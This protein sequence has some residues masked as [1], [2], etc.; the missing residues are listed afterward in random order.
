MHVGSNGGTVHDKIS[1]ECGVFLLYYAFGCVG[2][3]VD[4]NLELFLSSVH[5]PGTATARRQTAEVWQT[6][7]TI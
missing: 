3:L 4:C 5:L 2:L 6:R 1:V 7:A